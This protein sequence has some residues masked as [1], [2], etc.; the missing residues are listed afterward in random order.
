MNTKK[1]IEKIKESW[2]K[3]KSDDFN[4]ELIQQY[5][6]KSDKSHAFQVIS[7]RTM[8]DIDFQELFMFID[9]TH[10]SVGQQFLF[11]QLCVINSPVSFDKQEQLIDYYTQH[12]SERI[13]AQRCLSKLN[14]AYNLPALF[15]DEYI[16][17]PRWFWV[18]PTLSIST[19]F[20]LILT[21]FFPKFLL[22]L[23]VFSITNLLIHYWNKN[24]LYTYSGSIAQLLTLCK[25]SK[26]FLNTQ[27]ESHVQ[28]AVKKIEEEKT[29]MSLFS[30]ESKNHSDL[31]AILYTILEYLKIL[32]LVEPL[33]VFS[34][35]QKLNRKRTEMYQLFRYIGEIDTA[36]SLASLRTGLPCFCRPIFSDQPPTLA[37]DEIYHPLI[38]ECITNS[39]HI[40]DKSILL[41]GSNM[42]GKTTFIRTIGINVLCAQTIN[43]CFAQSMT[44]VPMRIYSAIRITDDLMNERSYYFEEVATV[45]QLIDESQSDNYSL[46]LLD[47]IFKGTNTLERIAAGKAVL[48]YIAQGKNLVFVSTHDIEL[49]NLLS[50][51]YELYHFTEVIKNNEVYF[52]YRLKPGNLATRNAI[53]ILE[54]NNYPTELIAEAQRISNLI[55]A[56]N[57]CSILV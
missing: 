18:I 41:T 14:D 20:S 36:I 11:N 51:S 6:L 8:N 40:H 13:Q 42:S 31:A 29:G 54:L 32:F 35:L 45:K 16:S 24:N 52:D 56:D 26:A 37:F 12:E 46:F 43:T 10:S 55:S 38:D 3:L 39:L 17:K 34:V 1:E 49:T 57:L 47:E 4:F 5:F 50:D 48:S 27:Y 30:T 22:T 23:I 19:L 7:E 28:T 2:G 33:A 53:R 15:Q 44:L 9:R 25:V 21:F